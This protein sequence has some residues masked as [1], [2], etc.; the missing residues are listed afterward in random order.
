MLIMIKKKTAVRTWAAFTKIKARIESE[1]DPGDKDKY[2]IQQMRFDPG[3]EFRGRFIEGMHDNKI[4]GKRGTTGRHS[5]QG[6]AEN[7]NGRTQRVATAMATTAMG[8]NIKKYGPSLGGELAEWA[9][10][11]I[12]HTK[13]TAE[14]KKLD[15]R[16]L[17]E[18]EMDLSFQ[19]CQQQR[20]SEGI[21]IAL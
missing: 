1:T 12:N 19:F 21:W 3:S 6:D 10:E 9:S 20:V 8:D 13:I 5:N 4:I 15:M 7:R 17:M 16:K 18:E 11:A 14:Q 2:R